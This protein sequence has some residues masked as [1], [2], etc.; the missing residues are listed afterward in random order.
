MHSPLQMKHSSAWCKRR[1]RRWLI[2]YRW[3]HHQDALRQHIHFFNDPFFRRF[4]G[5]EFGRQ[6]QPPERRQQGI[7][8]G[9]IVSSNGYILTNNH[10]IDQADEIRVVFGDKREFQGTLIGT[11]PKT[12]L[13]IIKIDATDLP[14]LPWGDSDQLQVG[15]MVLAVGNPF[16]LN[17]TVTMGIISAVGRANVGIVDYEDFIQTDAAINPGNSGGA[18]VNLSGQLIGI[19]TAIFSRS[20][21][22]MG[23]GFAIPSRMAKAV[24]TSLIE[25]GEVIRG[26]LGVSIQ[27]LNPTLA[28]QFDAPDTKGVLV[29]DIIENS[30]AEEAT[31]QRGDIIRQY[32]GGTVNDAVH[33]R[34][35]VAETSPGTSVPLIILR[36]GESQTVV[37][38][39]G[40]LPQDLTALSPTQGTQG[41][42]ALSG[43][44]VNPVPHGRTRGDVGVIVQDVKQ[45]SSAQRAGLRRG[46]ILLEINR[47]RISGVRAFKKVAGSLD[48]RKPVLVLLRRGNTT[49]FLTI[50][51][52]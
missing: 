38:K 9:V 14:S 19:N 1:D 3:Q 27:D 33:L 48:P 44:T 13:A 28:K 50:S 25:H 24:M 11:D 6:F 36:D 17:Q 35:L 43:I 10:V 26:W 39:I 22:Y 41:T 23:I 37:V 21:G 20:G 4:F 40:T 51:P 42:R 49:I 52:E 8:S 30:P 2:S 32:R 31:I 12:D 29:G 5:D 34:S 47:G 45:G 15:E 46:D 7:G 16:G 18:L